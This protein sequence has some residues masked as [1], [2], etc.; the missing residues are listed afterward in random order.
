ME[1]EQI[2][3]IEITK[4]FLIIGTI[5]ISSCSASIA[6][7]QDYCI[8][9]KNWLSID[10][11]SHGLILGQFLGPFILNT[12]IFVGYRVRGLKG[13]IAALIAFLLPSIIYVIFISAL[14]MYFHK[15]PSFQSALNGVSL[16]II[17]LILSV[18]YRIGK[19]RMKSIESI[20][21][22]LLSI[23]LFMVLKFPVVGILLMAL[24]YS[25]IKIKF[26]N[27][28]YLNENS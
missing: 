27:K 22:M 25:F 14:Y 17:A 7:V 20:I 18:A 26:L 13:A 9:K 1:N 28:G 15:L 16:A 3:L 8:E 19:G 6:L 10:E 21:L 24:F 5:G 12:V 2:S 23:F 4:V 11:F